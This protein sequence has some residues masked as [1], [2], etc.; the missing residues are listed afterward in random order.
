MHTYSVQPYLS[1]PN[2]TEDNSV[3]GNITQ[4][5]RIMRKMRVN[6]N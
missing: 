1:D 5:G 6:I 3:I 2:G 4:Y